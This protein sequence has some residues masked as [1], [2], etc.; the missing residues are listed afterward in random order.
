MEDVKSDQSDKRHCQK[1]KR[2]Q[3]FFKM[4]CL[5]TVLVR[6]VAFTGIIIM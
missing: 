4:V 2:I 3:E 5:V 6:A 1:E